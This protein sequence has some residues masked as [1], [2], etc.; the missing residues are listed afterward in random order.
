MSETDGS[1]FLVPNI[2][3]KR[4]IETIKSKVFSPLHQAVI[5]M[6]GNRLS[7]LEV[8]IIW[9]WVVFLT[10]NLLGS[11]PRYVPVGREYFHILQYNYIWTTFPKCG[12]CV[13]WNGF[14][15]G[16]A[17][18]FIDIHGPS[19]HPLT[20]LTTLLFGVA[21]GGKALIIGSIFIAA[22]AQWWVAKVMGFRRIVRVW[23]ACLVAAGG[24]LAGRMEIGNVGLVLSTA[25]AGLVLAALIDLI[26]NKER[27]SPVALGITLALLILAGQGYLQLGTAILLIFSVF[28]FFFGSGQPFHHFMRKYLFAATL[29]FLLIGFFIVP[30]LNFLPN[31]AKETDPY[32]SQI[33]VFE[34]LPLNLVI[35]DLDFYK[36]EILGKSGNA[37]LYNTFVGWF[38]IIFAAVAIRLAPS[39]QRKFLVYLIL[40]LGLVYL[41]SSRQFYQGLLKVIPAVDMIR[42]ASLIS[43]MA[44]PLVAILAAWG[45]NLVL[46]RDWGRLVFMRNGDQQG[47]VSV[48]WV[49][50]LVLMAVSLYQVYQFSHSF[51]YL[52]EKDISQEEFEALFTQSAQ[53]I[54]PPF[55]EF[56]WLD[57]AFNQEMKIANV[58]RPWR[59]E[60]REIPSPYRE[61]SRNEEDT[62]KTGYIGKAGGMFLIEYADNQYAMIETKDGDLI[63]CRAAALGGKIDVV[64]ESH[65]GGVLTVMENNHNGWKVWINGQKS[66][67]LY[68]T[69]LSVDLSPGHNSVSFRYRPWD[70]LIGTLLTIS[71]IA[72]AIWLTIKQQGCAHPTNGDF[73]EKTIIRE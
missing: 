50:L 44:V 62:E 34:F 33:Q 26:Q 59:W 13:L 70:V 29:A 71:G 67:K 58:F 16:G 27:R 31:F 45:I 40:A 25:S 1:P 56:F 68:G 12:T 52:V 61:L 19:L 3:P 53:W 8:I 24:H 11:N 73:G 23:S 42:N 20:I 60:A 4:L 18:S 55:G 22:M 49:T 47:S 36:A 65:D 66:D 54:Q 21:N 51:L 46:D 38:P 7:Y 69:W 15:N 41:I 35:N 14:L 6:W 30:F 10:F 37:Y 32:L 28:F 64:C 72:F 5:Q 2:T 57:D 17:P 9:C 39:K 63:P 48:A 43:G